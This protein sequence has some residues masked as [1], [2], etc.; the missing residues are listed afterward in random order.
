MESDWSIIS[1]LP[2]MPTVA[3]I[4]GTPILTII[5]NYEPN[6]IITKDNSTTLE[7]LR[8]SKTEAG[9]QLRA[10]IGHVKAF[11]TGAHLEY[12]PFSIK[13]YTAFAYPIAPFVSLGFNFVG[14]NPYTYSK[15]GPLDDPKMFSMNFGVISNRNPVP[16]GLLW[17]AGRIQV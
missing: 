12:Y 11:E 15:L 3:A 10:M 9:E 17:L 5:L 7:K 4:P 13:D 6:W 16:H 1:T 14:Y 2:I 8:R